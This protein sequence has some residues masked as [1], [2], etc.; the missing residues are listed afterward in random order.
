MCVQITKIAVV[1]EKV[2]LPLFSFRKFLKNQTKRCFAEGPV[3][4]LNVACFNSY[5]Q[6]RLDKVKN[7]LQHPSGAVF[8]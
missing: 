1:C 8:V 4:L 2:I 6:L 5:R 7:T 3:N